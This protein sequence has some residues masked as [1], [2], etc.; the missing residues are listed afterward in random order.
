MKNGCLYASENNL[1]YGK[2]W[3]KTFLVSLRC[4]PFLFARP[5]VLGQA[6]GGPD[7]GSRAAP[8]CGQRG[9]TSARLVWRTPARSDG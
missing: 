7:L 9:A 6:E 1:V 5:L 3:G 8:C 4:I 2:D